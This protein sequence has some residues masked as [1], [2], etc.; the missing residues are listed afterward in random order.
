MFSGG[1][2]L[3]LVSANHAIVLG[4]ASVGQL[5]LLPLWRI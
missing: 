4:T 1:F 2:L 5:S 3:F